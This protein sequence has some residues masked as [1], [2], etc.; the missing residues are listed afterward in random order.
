MN[1]DGLLIFFLGLEEC[2]RLEVEGARNDIGGKDLLSR[3]EVSNDRVVVTAGVGDIA[4]DTGEVALE[5]NE[6]LVSLLRSG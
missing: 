4:L 2:P 6:V 3:V 1:L 5:L